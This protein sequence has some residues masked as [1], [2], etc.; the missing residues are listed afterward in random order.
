M[1]HCRAGSREE[2]HGLTW[3]SERAWACDMVAAACGDCGVGW[4]CLWWCRRRL[5]RQ[6]GRGSLEVK[7]KA[8]QLGAPI[9]DSPSP[10]RSYFGKRLGQRRMQCAH[11]P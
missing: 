1:V 5:C 2:H 3:S 7:F 9:G 4:R 6:M 11:V 8:Q 10:A